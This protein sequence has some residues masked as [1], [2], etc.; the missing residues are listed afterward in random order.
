MRFAHE[1][2]ED[3]EDRLEAMLDHADGEHDDNLPTHEQENTH[4]E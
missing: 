4:D 3:Y 2:P 1:Y